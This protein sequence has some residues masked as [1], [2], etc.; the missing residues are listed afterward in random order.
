[1]WAKRRRHHP[2]SHHV[3]I[4]QEAE[5]PPSGDAGFNV[6][7]DYQ[8]A[9]VLTLNQSSLS[10]FEVSTFKRGRA[11]QLVRSYNASRELSRSERLRRESGKFCPRN[12]EAKT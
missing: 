11:E 8:S 6:S 2:N 1:L 9:P 5:L 3:S 10:N 7:V 12:G 4:S